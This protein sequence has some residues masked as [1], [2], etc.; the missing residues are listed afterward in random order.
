LRET[1]GLKE[2]EIFFDEETGLLTISTERTIFE[3][4]SASARNYL[5]KAI[6]DEIKVKVTDQSFGYWSGRLAFGRATN[7]E[8]DSATIILD[9]MDFKEGNITLMESLNSNP[10]TLGLVF[11]HELVHAI[12]RTVDPTTAELQGNRIKR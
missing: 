6:Q 2:S 8:P 11:F 5:Q 12:D 1:T 4:G 7:F 10:Y 9:F 3:S